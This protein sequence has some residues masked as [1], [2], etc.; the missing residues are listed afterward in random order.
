MAGEPKKDAAK[1]LEELRVALAAAEAQR[2]RALAIAAANEG[3]IRAQKEI[4]ELTS[5]HQG[6]AELGDA[7]TS[8]TRNSEAIPDE[9][10]SGSKPSEH[11]SKS[12]ATGLNVLGHAGPPDPPQLMRGMT[13]TT[14]ELISN[15]VIFF[16]FYLLLAIPTYIL[17]YFG[18]NSLIVHSFVSAAGASN[19]FF[20][21]H[22]FC[23][24][25][26]VVITWWRGFVIKSSWIAVFPFF[27]GI[28]DLVPGFTLFF[29]LPTLMHVLAI[30]FSVK[31]QSTDDVR[32]EFGIPCLIGYVAIAVGV[33]AVGTSLA[34][35]NAAVS[36]GVTQWLGPK[37]STEMPITT[38]I[39]PPAMQKDP[40]PSYSCSSPCS[41]C[42]KVTGVCLVQ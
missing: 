27:A 17:P 14:F 15:P 5:Q 34:L 31:Q 23:V 37:V 25:G 32:T 16:V 33:F 12:P 40:R 8:Y 10:R 21:L 3:L 35:N 26:L 39:R 42:D 24:T 29:L 28:F 20:W 30:V 19:P 11:S 13:S 9:G 36:G 7:P 4:I 22:V 41:Y 38:P 18:S 6:S 2:D 1:S